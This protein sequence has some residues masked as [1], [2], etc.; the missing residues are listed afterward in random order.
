MKLKFLVATFILTAW[1]GSAFASPYSLIYQKENRW[2]AIDDANG[3]RS[4]LRDAKKEKI[5]SFN[6]KLPTTNRD[7]TV[8]RLIVLRDIL[9]KQLGKAVTIE[10]IDGDVKNNEIIVTFK[11]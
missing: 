9:E 6:V 8:E 7:V 1:V 2:V 5:Y 11:K 4:L 10:E 3:L